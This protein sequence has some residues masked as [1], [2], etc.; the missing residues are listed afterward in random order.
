MKSILILV[1]SLLLASCVSQPL[2]NKFPCNKNLDTL[3]AEITKICID[4]GLILGNR[5]VTDKGVLSFSEP[6]GV[7]YTFTWDFVFQ[8]D[9]IVAYPRLITDM[10]Y[11]YG[12]SEVM[13]GN[14]TYNGHTVYWNVRARIEKL[15]GSKVIIVE[16]EE[17]KSMKDE[18]LSE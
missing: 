1:V 15:C 2:Y 12:R 7:M 3:Q 4:E 16:S 11:R 17:K 9:F 10:G 5:S 8:K 18:S 13:L 6:Q 14:S